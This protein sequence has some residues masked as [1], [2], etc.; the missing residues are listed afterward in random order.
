MVYILYN[1]G[2][3]GLLFAK[4]LFLHT[5]AAKSSLSTV[6]FFFP[7]LFLSSGENVPKKIWPYWHWRYNWKKDERNTFLLPASLPHVT[8]AD[9]TSWEPLQQRHGNAVAELGLLQWRWSKKKHW[10]MDLRRNA[11]QMAWSDRRMLTKC[12][13]IDKVLS[14]VPAI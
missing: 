2:H 4:F 8:P 11:W 12:R 7:F 10:E 9:W 6:L 5:N 3:R 13:P 14:T 1:G